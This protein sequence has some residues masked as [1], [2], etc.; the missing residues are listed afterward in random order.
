MSEK[1]NRPAPREDLPFT[2]ETALQKVSKLRPKRHGL[3]D[4]DGRKPGARSVLDRIELCGM[5]CFGKS[6][7][8]RPTAARP[9]ED[10]GKIRYSCSVGETPAISGPARR[11]VSISWLRASSRSAARRAACSRSSSGGA[12]RGSYMRGMTVARA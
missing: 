4:R 2:V 7:G 6:P 5:R 9:A 10:A 11:R 3:G 12:F 8:C 1:F